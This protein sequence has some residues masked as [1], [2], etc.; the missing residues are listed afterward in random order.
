[1]AKTI[2]I[3]ED[4]SFLVKMLKLNLEEIEDVNVAIAANGEIA[5]EKI[6]ESLPD[7]LLLDL[8]MPKI[9]GFSVLEHIKEKG[10]DVPIVI[11]SN[12]SQ[13]IDQKKCNE[14][15]C[16]DYFVKS[17]MDVDEL[18]KKLQTYL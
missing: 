4:D 14:L 7:L 6:D 3:A 8:L 18:V 1:M 11:L 10:L 2:L 12:L 5:I 13:E 17:D 9:D 15:G 16:K